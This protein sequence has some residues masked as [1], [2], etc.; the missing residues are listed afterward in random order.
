FHSYRCDCGPQLHEA[1][2][3]INE[4]ESGILLYMRQEGRGIGL[5]NK[6]RAYHLQDEGLDTVKANEK[7]GFKADQRDYAV[8]AKMLKELG[9]KSVQLLTNNP[10]KLASLRKYGID[11]VER[12]PLEIKARD[13][14]R[15][16]LTTKAKKLG[17]LL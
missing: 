16:Y 5:L 4:A 2:R 10:K 13:E 17:H 3:L 7:L 9:V 14:N 1:L 11:V 8:S 12:I 6:L 15:R